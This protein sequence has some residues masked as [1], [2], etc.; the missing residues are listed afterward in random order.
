MLHIPVKTFIAF[1]IL[2]FA[3]CSNSEKQRA[4]SEKIGRDKIAETFTYCK[5]NGSDIVYAFFI[6]MNMHSGKNRFFVWDF[7]T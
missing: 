7:P 3:M 5:K 4:V 6:D 1:G 2:V